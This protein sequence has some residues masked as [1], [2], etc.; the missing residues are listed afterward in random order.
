M[1]NIIN[2]FFFAAALILAF[3]IGMLLCKY[4]LEKN[5]FKNKEKLQRQAAGIDD[6]EF[7]NNFLCEGFAK[8]LLSY[9]VKVAY[10]LSFISS[11]AKIS[12]KFV[13]SNTLNSKMQK[14]CF[15]ANMPDVFRNY[16][17]REIQIRLSFI[18]CLL[19]ALIGSVFSYLLMFILFIAG[20]ILGI[21]L[22]V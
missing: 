17:Y 9:M 1:K 2:I 18:F 22:P 5:N 13:K 14:L 16:A 12:L 10:A 21:Y 19:G 7:N 4:F 15:Q 8:K 20:I 3:T 11:E 6:A